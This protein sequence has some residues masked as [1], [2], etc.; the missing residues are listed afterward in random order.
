[1]KYK[2]KEQQVQELEEREMT[3]LKNLRHLKAILTEK[4]KNIQQFKEEYQHFK[5]LKQYQDDQ[6]R[7][8]VQQQRIS[9]PQPSYVPFLCGG[10][11]Y[12]FIIF[13]ISIIIRQI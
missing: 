7:F 2:K 10:I 11:I 8:V 9:A 1:M 5:S 12:G 4:D 3:R 6:L 13:I